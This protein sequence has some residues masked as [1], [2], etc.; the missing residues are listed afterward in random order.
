MTTQDAVSI[1]ND[2]RVFFHSPEI[3]AALTM[4]MDALKGCGE[5]KCRLDLEAIARS[6]DDDLK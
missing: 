4:G 6:F 1:L 2:I 3:D 5:C